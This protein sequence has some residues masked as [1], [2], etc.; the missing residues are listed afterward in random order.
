MSKKER[1]ICKFGIDFKK[2][3][4][5]CCCNLSSDD[6]FLRGQDPVV[7]KVDST[8]YCI[9]YLYPV[10]S[11]IGFPNTYPVDSDLSG[12]ECYPAFEQLGLG[13]KMGM[14]FKGQL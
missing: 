13:L 9:K 3:L 8:I 10:D 4:F 1:Q 6:I 11:A 12:G 7:Q 14:D 5:C 2:Y